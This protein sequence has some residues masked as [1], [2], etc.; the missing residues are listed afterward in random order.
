MAE[1]GVWRGKGTFKLQRLQIGHE[2]HVSKRGRRRDHTNLIFLKRGNADNEKLE[3][4]Y[5]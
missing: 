2:T 5:L 1:V 3:V 4:N